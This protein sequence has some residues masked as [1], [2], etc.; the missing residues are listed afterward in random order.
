MFDGYPERGSIVDL[1]CHTLASDGSLTLEELHA[2]GHAAGLAALAVTDHDTLKGWADHI[3]TIG[4]FRDPVIVPGVELS[5]NAEG[6]NRSFHVLGLGI[7][8][9]GSIRKKLSWLQNS[10]QNRNRAM[11]EK[12]ADLNIPLD[13][14]DSVNIL[15]NPTAG[16]AHVAEALFRAGHVRTPGESYEQWIGYECPAYVQRERLSITDAIDIIHEDGGVSVLC[17]PQIYGMD[18]TALQVFLRDLKDRGLDAVEV[19]HS[20]HTEDFTEQLSAL[21]EEIGLLASGGSDFHGTVKPGIAVGI[22]KG[23]LNIPRSIYDRLISR[24]E[25]IRAATAS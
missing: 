10:R 25:E 24:I 20:D 18:F 4:H 11:I 13:Q 14:E 5:T 12:L 9:S 17:H 1:H 7:R 19:Y 16:R 2:F 21:A 8:P 22:G 6:I 3:E 15:E 23:N